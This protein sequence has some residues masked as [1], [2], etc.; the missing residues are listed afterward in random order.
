MK[1]VSIFIVD[2]NN[3]LR[4]ALQE[5]IFLSGS[6][7][8]VG[9]VGT[10]Q[11][12]LH[13]IPIKKPDIVLMDVS[14]GSSTNGIDLIRILKPKLPNTK[15]LICSVHDEEEKILQGFYAGAGGYLLKTTAPHHLL[16]SIHE[17]NG[18]G[19][20]ISK[21][22]AKILIQSLKE[23]SVNTKVNKEIFT[24]NQLTKRETEMLELL[25][26]GLMYK[27]I[28]AQA[29]VS[30]ETVRKHVYRI[31]QKLEVTNRIAAVN[32]LYGR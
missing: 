1:P 2:D 4:K 12:A 17:L 32:K 30:A 21:E 24:L 6:C 29:G 7:L 15:F 9:S 25:S 5:I 3:E 16:E 14:L 31:Y 18:G 27:E 13:E 26:Q 10:C 22:I 23:E 28:A 11:E 19:A 8:L 20:P